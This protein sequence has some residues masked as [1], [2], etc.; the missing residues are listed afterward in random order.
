MQKI[1]LV[2]LTPAA[3]QGLYQDSIQDVQEVVN[4]LNVQLRRD[5]VPAW[6]VADVAVE[7]LGRGDHATGPTVYLQ[8]K[9]DVPN[10]LGYHDEHGNGQPYAI[11]SLELCQALEE[12]W[13]VTV[14][15]EI[16]ELLG[17]PDVDL[18]VPGPRPAPYQ[19]S[20]VFWWREMCDAVQADSYGISGVRVSNFVLPAYFKPHKP[21]K[22]NF[23][24]RALPALGLRPGG[25]MGYYDPGS[26]HIVQVTADEKAVARLTARSAF[27]GSRAHRR[28]A[29]ST[30]ASDHP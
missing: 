6:G 14:S 1:H 10:A 28:V 3:A 8:P 4:A 12:P 19:G 9:T 5:F 29:V 27:P 21:G 16:L 11:V 7:V 20:Q 17:N 30:G 22:T 15:H 24:G 13:S 2:D 26:Q 18:Y 25:Y 23:L